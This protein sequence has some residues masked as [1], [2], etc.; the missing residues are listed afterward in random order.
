MTDLLTPTHKIPLYT[1][2]W[3]QCVN[4]NWWPTSLW[5]RFQEQISWYDDTTVKHKQLL[6][7]FWYWCCRWCRCCHVSHHW[8]RHV[9]H[10]CGDWSSSGQIPVAAYHRDSGLGNSAG[11]LRNVSSYS[12]PE[13]EYQTG[14]QTNIRTLEIAN[15]M[16]TFDK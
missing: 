4:Y 1:V 10:H 8:G 6:L 13:H 5:W 16:I 2:E 9:G 11:H 3:K 12:N 14:K 15:N 7:V